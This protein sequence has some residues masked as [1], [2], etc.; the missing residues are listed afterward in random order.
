MA[1][2]RNNVRRRKQQSKQQNGGSGAKKKRAPL[3]LISYKPS[4]TKVL[5]SRRGGAV[6]VSSKIV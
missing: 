3:P 1:K 4:N 6:G 5:K 2:T